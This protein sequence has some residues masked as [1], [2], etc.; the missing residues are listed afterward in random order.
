MKTCSQGLLFYTAALTCTLAFSFAPA[1]TRA[2]SQTTTPATHTIFVR[3]DGSFFPETKSI[4]EG[5]SVA[6]VGPVAQDFTPGLGPTFSVVRT[7]LADI[8][9]NVACMTSSA[10]YNINHDDPELDNELTGPLHRG[11]S[12]IFALGPEDTTGFVEGPNS[13]ACEQIG[14]AAGTA[15]VSSSEEWR[16]ED[17]FATRLCRKVDTRS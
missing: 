12:G 14:A 8:E 5:D 1:D 10:R 3:A 16:Q 6:F 2:Q 11:S 7:K 17:G 15:P 4:Q 9:A 13:E